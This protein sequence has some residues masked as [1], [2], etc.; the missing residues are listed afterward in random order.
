MRKAWVSMILA[1]LLVG[2]LAFTVYSQQTGS[3]DSPAGS[4]A[5]QVL[6]GGVSQTVPVELTLHLSTTTGVQTVI[7]PLQL[8][9]NLNVGPMEAI[10]LNMAIEPATQFVS[11]ITGVEAIVESAAITATESITETETV[12]E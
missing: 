1:T 8:S 10:D 9:V 7:V 11:P 12:T 4:A 6:R 2:V 3:T 5:V